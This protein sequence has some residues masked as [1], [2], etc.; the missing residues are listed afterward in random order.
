[1]V[2]R[3]AA[4]GCMVALAA[5]SATWSRPVAARVTGQAA[6]P[7]TQSPPSA[8]AAPPQREL[9]DRY[10]VGCHNRRA[11]AAGQEPARKLTL[12]D[13]DITRIG[14]RADVW[15]RV[16]RKMRAGMMPPAGSRRP[17]RAAYDGLIAWLEGELDKRAT[18]YAPP[19]RHRLLRPS[20]ETVIL[21]R[22][23]LHV[24]VARF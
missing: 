16:V 4:V 24:D 2:R 13:L 11:R 9:L 21:G 6:D 14:D 18:P 7:R 5:V 17:D 19:A 10:C 23:A 3:I 20:Y 22:L 8:P 12:D 1:M 15:E